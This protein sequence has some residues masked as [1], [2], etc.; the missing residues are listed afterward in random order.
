MV[1]YVRICYFLLGTSDTLARFLL[2]LIVLFLHDNDD[3]H[4]YIHTM[5]KTCQSSFSLCVSFAQVITSYTRIKEHQK[6]NSKPKENL[7]VSCSLP[8]SPLCPFA[9]YL[10]GIVI[11]FIL[12]DLFYCMIDIRR[13]T[14]DHQDDNNNEQQR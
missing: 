12:L 2:F 5:K 1:V 4:T 3:T 8:L 7:F 10:D 13:I 11:L 14:N 6:Q 9:L